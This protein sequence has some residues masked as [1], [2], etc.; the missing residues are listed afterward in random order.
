MLRLSALLLFVVSSLRAGDPP[1]LV[2]A[3]AHNDYEHAR[4]LL[5]AL[6]RGFCSVEADVY[7]VGGELLVAHDRKDVK[8]E[9]TLR[10]LYLEPLRE[11]VKRNGGLIHRGGPTIVLLVDVKSEAAATYAV[12]HEQL[13]PYAH[14]LTTFRDGRASPSAIAVIVSGN[15]AREQMIA[16]PV[17]YAALDGRSADLDLNPAAA[18]V[19]LVSDNWEKLFAWRWQGEM[20]ADQRAALRRWIERAHQQ[21]RKV[22]FWNTPDRPEAW[23]FLLDAGVDVI[24]TDDLDGL[25]RFFAARNGR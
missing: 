21:G 22:R 7:L 4:P 15:R 5:D 11:R 1:P 8:P 24:G 18:L 2:H 12:L 20:P 10:S 3:H 13:M 17:R 6:D 14:M 25:Q 16:Q 19:P 9:R 23:A